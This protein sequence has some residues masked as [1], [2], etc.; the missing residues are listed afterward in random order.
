MRSVIKTPFNQNLHMTDIIFT[1]I[2][3][4]LPI[5]QK[6]EAETSLL[7]LSPKINVLS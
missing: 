1:R 5:K 6:R 7:I 4:H 3:H 2:P